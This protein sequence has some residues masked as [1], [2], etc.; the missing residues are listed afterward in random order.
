MMHMLDKAMK[1]DAVCITDRRNRRNKFSHCSSK[2]AISIDKN[3]MDSVLRSI[4]SN[5]RISQFSNNQQVN[6]IRV[7]ILF[8]PN[9]DDSR[10]NIQLAI[11]G[12]IEYLNVALMNS[13]ITNMRVELAHSQEINYIEGNR[14]HT[15]H[16][17]TLRVDNR[18]AQLR[19]Q[20]FADFVGFMIDDLDIGVLPN[21]VGTCG[22]GFTAFTAAFAFFTMHSGTNCDGR[23][24]AHEFGHNMGAEHNR[25]EDGSTLFGNGFSFTSNQGQ[26]RTI[27]SDRGGRT[28]QHFSNPTIIFG[29]SPTGTTDREDVARLFR[30]RAVVASSFA[31]PPPSNI[32][33]PRLRVR[34]EFC[35]GLNTLTW[36]NIS[37]A[38]RYEIFRGFSTNVNSAR[39]FTTTTGTNYFL[40]VGRGRTYFWVRACDN[41]ECSAFSNRG[42][43]IFRNVC[44]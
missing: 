30:E 23:V 44:F 32:A 19:N 31:P 38:T 36:N 24:L 1:E 5:A 28:I 6:V 37:G 26:L 9:A 13:N 14:T 35:R 34:P 12:R 8:T 20:H 2:N 10:A 43:A 15:Q 29:G 39:F 40:N 17:N 4:E 41:N 25:D 33:S 3:E 7:M 27:M 18:V 21:G 22:R 11:Q 42:V 16:L